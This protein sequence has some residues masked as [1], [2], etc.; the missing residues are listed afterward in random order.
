MARPE[1]VEPTTSGFGG[2]HSI[3]LSYGRVARVRILAKSCA[4]AN[5]RTGSGGQTTVD[6]G[7]FVGQFL[8]FIDHGEVRWPI[9]VGQVSLRFPVDRDAERM[10]STALDLQ[11]RVARV[12]NAVAATIAAL[13]LRLAIG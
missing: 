4:C 13:I 1:G 2:L 6:I 12:L 10:Y 5:Q 8:D 7:Y 11:Q 9:H 3:Q